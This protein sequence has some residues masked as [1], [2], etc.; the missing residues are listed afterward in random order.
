MQG[1]ILYFFPWW[2]RKAAKTVGYKQNPL[3]AL[4]LVMSTS[5]WCKARTS[6]LAV[7]AYSNLIFR[8][9]TNIYQHPV[10]QGTHSMKGLYMSYCLLQR[11]TEKTEK[12][13]NTTALCHYIPDVFQSG[14]FILLFHSSKEPWLL[15]AHN[16]KLKKMDFLLYDLTWTRKTLQKGVIAVGQ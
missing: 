15:K 7:V 8:L 3:L 1:D 16:S 13:E 11:R 14:G 12:G 4:L 10:F 6:C 5:A 2:D 9:W